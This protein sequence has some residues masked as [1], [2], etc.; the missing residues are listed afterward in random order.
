MVDMLGI[1]QVHIYDQVFLTLITSYSNAK[2]NQLTSSS[3]EKCSALPSV[4][5]LN[6]IVHFSTIRHHAPCSPI[7]YKNLSF[8]KFIKNMNKEEVIEYQLYI[9]FCTR[10]I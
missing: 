5:C 7:I 8:F 3:L 6:T 10:V 1:S 4:P 9:D 2:R